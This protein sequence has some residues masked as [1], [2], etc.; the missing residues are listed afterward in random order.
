MNQPAAR[1]RRPAW[2]RKNP[3][4]AEVVES[5]RMSGAD[6]EK[7][8]RHYRFAIGESGLDY[9]VGDGLGVRPINDPA[10]VSAIIEAL[11]TPAETEIA[12]KDADLWTVLS[13][14]VEISV[15]SIDLLE[16]MDGR[17]HD[18]ELEHALATRDK[19]ALEAWLWGR[20]VLDVLR[21]AGPGCLPPDEFVGLLGR[22]QHRTYSISSSLLSHPGEIHTIVSTVRYRSAG[23]ARGGVCS[24]YLADRV[25]VGDR[26]GVFILPNRS[27]RLPAN[28][29]T[30]VIMVGPGTGV[31]PFRAF[32][33]DRRGR[34]AGGRNWLFF[35]EQH[36]ASDYHYQE[37]FE[38]FLADG[39]LDRLDLAFS[40][41]VPLRDGVAKDYVQAHM[42]RRGAD[43]YSWLEDGAHLYVCGDATR[44]AKDV[45]DALLHIVREH[46]G[47]GDDAA[48]DYLGALRKERRYL[49]DVY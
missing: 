32:L 7:D 18:G 34:G 33:H 22:L 46:G 31:A 39:T 20:D 26:V 2:N 15:P 6:S 3:Y 41:D 27:F 35:G 38:G 40:R 19:Q 49:R 14:Q 12:G 1:T 23:R 8:V 47:L 13:T 48:H 42:I 17:T 37:E 28:D 30:P 11:G 43:L 9:Q 4:L 24:T 21:M 16:A 29:E 36:R 5:R 10:L 44:M 45:D 25:D